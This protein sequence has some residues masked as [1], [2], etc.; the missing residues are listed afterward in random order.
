MKAR[1]AVRKAI[2]NQVEHRGFSLVE[3]LSPCPT[4]WK[5]QPLQAWKWIEDQMLPVFPL[6]VCKDVS[7][8][9]QIL[10]PARPALPTSAVAGILDLAVPS[11]PQAVADEDATVPIETKEFKIAGFGG[12][13]VLFMG[14]TLATVAMI[15]GYHV[16]WLPSYGPEMRGGTANCN[17]VLSCHAIGTPLVD[18]PDI[19]IAMNAP[20]LRRFQETVKSGGLVVYDSSVIVESSLSKEREILAVPAAKMAHELGDAKVANVIILGAL[21]TKCPI[22]KRAHVLSAIESSVGNENLRSLNR[23]ALEAGRLYLATAG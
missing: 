10:P 21:L 12:Q 16:T 8:S 14:V 3:V 1:Q 5:L 4:G 9:R 18:T 7:T 13:G 2:R 23:K 15:E 17:V 22:L 20:S 19:L 11:P 6:G